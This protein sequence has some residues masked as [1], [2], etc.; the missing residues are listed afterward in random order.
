MLASAAVN[1]LRKMVWYLLC[2]LDVYG[3]KEVSA[4][5]IQTLLEK[6]KVFPILF[7]KI[8]EGETILLKAFAKMIREMNKNHSQQ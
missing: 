2:K 3:A 1:N 5:W 4:N 7:P 6:N 8:E